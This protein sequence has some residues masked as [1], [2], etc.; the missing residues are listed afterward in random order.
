MHIWSNYGAYVSLPKSN[1]YLQMHLGSYYIE[2]RLFHLKYNSLENKGCK[3]E[4]KVHFH[5][6]LNAFKSIRIELPLF[7]TC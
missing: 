4:L 7:N 6:V 1:K 5:L 3:N 2:E